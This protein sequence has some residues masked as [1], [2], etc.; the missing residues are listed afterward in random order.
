VNFG[1]S[2]SKFYNTSLNSVNTDIHVRLKRIF[3]IEKNKYSF[4]IKTIAEDLDSHEKIVSQKKTFS[5]EI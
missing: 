4:Y 1:K 3:M 2:G 5:S